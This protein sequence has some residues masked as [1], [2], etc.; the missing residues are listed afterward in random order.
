MKGQTGL[1]V[2][3]G[4]LA[5]ISTAIAWGGDDNDRSNGSRHRDRIEIRLAGVNEVPAVSSPGTGRFKAR[6]RESAGTIEYELTYGGL[7]AD[8][9]QSHIHFG[10]RHTN[11]GI[12]LF[13]CSNL[14]NGPAGTQACPLGA[15]PHTITGTLMSADV[16]GP[17][18]QG[19]AAGEFAEIIAAIRGGDA[20]VNVHSVTFPGGEI[21]GQLAD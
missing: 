17:A 11:G 9:K 15:G 7:Q 2:A 5:A 21:R 4:A 10:Q 13:L 18:G 1:S 16:I 3:L 20:Y 8:A 12:S 6:I 14:G 19:I